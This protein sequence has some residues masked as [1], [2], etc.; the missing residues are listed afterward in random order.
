MNRYRRQTQHSTALRGHSRGKTE[1]DHTTHRKHA[2]KERF[3]WIYGVHPVMHA[4]RCERVRRLFVHEENAIL[5]KMRT[6]LEL[7][8]TLWNDDQFAQRFGAACHQRI[9]AQCAPLAL[10]DKSL[11]AKLCTRNVLSLL[12]IL[13]RITDP[14]NFGACLR[15]A[16]S[17]GAQ[18][19]IFPQQHSA[20]LGAA[21][22][23]SAC[24]AIETLPL[25]AVRGLLPIV[26]TLRA[27]GVACVAASAHAPSTIYDYHWRPPVALIV[28]NEGAGVRAC[29]RQHC[30]ATLAIP[31]RGMVKSLNV[32]TALAVCLY[33]AQR[34]LAKNNQITA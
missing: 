28:G 7:P 19:V 20:A 4:L 30:D 1:S 17:A 29:L 18:A 22:A 8:V 23:K 31:M 24:G 25:I 10:Y 12:V 27:N 2:S 32:T 9:A 34:K 14:Q 15:C 21:T 11:I 26:Q 13:D 5:E 16:E 33:E 3:E 6:N